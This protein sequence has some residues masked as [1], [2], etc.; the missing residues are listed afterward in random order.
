MKNVLRL[1]KKQTLFGILSVSLGVL[2]TKA[3]EPIITEQN[4]PY[5]VNFGTGHF[6]N[7]PA[8][9]AT[10]RGIANSFKTN[11]ADVTTFPAANFTET[12]SLSTTTLTS[13]LSN[14]VGG[15]NVSGGANPHSYLEGGND[16]KLLI[17]LSTRLWSTFF[18]VKT[19]DNTDI[20]IG[21]SLQLTERAENNATTSPGLNLTAYLQYRTSSISG[22]NTVIGSEWNTESL[23]VGG[24]TNF[25]LTLPSSINNLPR[26]DFRIVNTQ[27]AGVTVSDLLSYA[28]DNI[29]VTGIPPLVNTVTAVAFRIKSVTPTSTSVLTQGKAFSVEVESISQNGSTYAVTSSAGFTLSVSSGSGTLGGTLTGT[30]LASTTSTIITGITYSKGEVFTLSVVSVSGQPLLSASFVLTIAG[31]PLA[32]LNVLYSENFENFNNVPKLNN[33]NVSVAG[34]TSYN[35][36]RAALNSGGSPTYG[37]AGFVV[38]RTA[39]G[40]WFG[41]GADNIGTTTYFDNTGSDNKD[42]NFV[43]AATS[44]FISTSTG[45]SRYL[46]LPAINL[47]GSNIKLSWQAMSRG[48]FAFRDSYKVKYSETAPSSPFNTEDFEL[49]STVPGVAVIINEPSRRVTNHSI[50]IPTNFENKIIYFAFELSTPGPGGDR[51]FLDN[52]LVTSGSSITGFNENTQ[53]ISTPIL[54]ATP[55]PASESITIQSAVSETVKIYN[56]IGNQVLTGTTNTSLAIGSLTKGMYVAVTTKGTVKFIVE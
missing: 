19:T 40:P 9:L 30:I 29:S 6:N 42:S 21:Y 23:T 46:V 33:Y 43:A 56:L 3:Q 17:T 18:S 22:W 7:Y 52:I 53:M 5:V 47:A 54:K 20:K 49:I 38:V 12:R 10:S 37:N 41:N 44:Y 1:I 31:D 25:N 55:N 27:T 28:I 15:S 14:T 50:S 36:D 26:V 51:I 8:G 16:A 35:I 13:P 24:I 2:E 48:S 45:A 11:I 32:G 4:L 34:M 39:R